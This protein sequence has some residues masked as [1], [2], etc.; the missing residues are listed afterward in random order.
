[1]TTAALE[2]LFTQMLFE[3]LD[4]VAYRR[5]CDKQDFCCVPEALVLGRNTER[6]KTT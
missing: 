3:I 6:S 1:L 5:S 4:L 2:K